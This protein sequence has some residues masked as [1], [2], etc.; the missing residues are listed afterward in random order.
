VVI[1][2]SVVLF[3]YRLGIAYVNRGQLGSRIGPSFAPYGLSG[4]RCRG[5]IH[6]LRLHWLRR[7]STTGTGGEKSAADLPIGI[8]ASL[9]IC[10]VALTFP[11]AAV[12]TGMVPWREVN[13]ESA[14]RA[15]V[16]GPRA[17]HRVHHQRWGAGWLTKCDAGQVLL[18][19][20]MLTRWPTMV[21]PKKFFVRCSPNNYALRGKNTILVGLLAAQWLE[22]RTP[23]DDI[24]RMVNIG[25]LLAFCHRLDCGAGAR[26]TNP[27]QAAPLRTP[28]YPLVPILAVISNGT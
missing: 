19:Q 3:V 5:R 27:G 16:P 22:A 14:D 1:R 4:I 20:Q 15:R 11:V 26:R 28:W 9:V 21:L 6:L 7:V 10:T 18:G 12:L 13:I 8:I 17:H 2:V 24:G 23:I 25:T